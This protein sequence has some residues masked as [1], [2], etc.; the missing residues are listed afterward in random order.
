MERIY[1]KLVRDN[2]PDII[3]NSGKECISNRCKDAYAKGRAGNCKGERC[4]RAYK[5]WFGI[6]Y[7]ELKAGYEGIS[8]SGRF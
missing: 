4:N 1:N 2:I 3:K 6:C 8:G 7:E 5:E